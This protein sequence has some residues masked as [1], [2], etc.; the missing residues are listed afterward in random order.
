MLAR[1][2]AWLPS[3]RLNK[4]LKDNL[5]YGKKPGT[6]VVELRKSRK[7]LRMRVVPWEDQQCQLSWTPKISQ[8]LNHQPGIIHQLI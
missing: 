2:L 8:T 1:S 5:A 6:P 4:Q 3:E 7:K